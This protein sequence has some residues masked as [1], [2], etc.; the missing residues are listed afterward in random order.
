MISIKIGGWSCGELQEADGVGS[1]IKIFY[2]NVA[3]EH[4]NQCQ[5]IPM[6]IRS[7]VK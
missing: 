2:K 3:E 4:L 6:N 1:E 7:R 5:L